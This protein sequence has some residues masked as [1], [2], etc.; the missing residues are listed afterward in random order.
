MPGKVLP[1][2]DCSCTDPATQG[3][4][5]VK[6]P[7]LLGNLLQMEQGGGDEKSAS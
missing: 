1:T 5:D 6:L 7:Q 2:K 3:T 4:A